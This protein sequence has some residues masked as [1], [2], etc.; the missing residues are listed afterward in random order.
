MRQITRAE[1]RFPNQCAVAH[2]QQADN[3][4]GV[5]AERAGR[6]RRIVGIANGHCHA[7]WIS[8]RIGVWSAAVERAWK[9]MLT[10]RYPIENAHAVELTGYTGLAASTPASLLKIQL[11]HRD[12]L[13][14]LVDLLEQ[15]TAMLTVDLSAAGMRSPSLWE[16]VSRKAV[17]LGLQRSDREG[18]SGFLVVGLSSSLMLDCGD[19]TFLHLLACQVATELRL[20]SMAT[21]F[22]W[23]RWSAIC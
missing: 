18:L 19:E 6:P 22:D 12:G 13:W 23:F 4:K 15:K 8:L 2:R 14:L 9:M 20:W 17:V 21:H 5:V 10:S 11:D 7:A 3:A 16:E 1:I